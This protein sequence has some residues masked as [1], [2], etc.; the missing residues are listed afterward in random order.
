MAEQWEVILY[1]NGRDIKAKIVRGTKNVVVNARARHI[2]RGL[3]VS[4]IKR[5]K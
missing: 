3:S 2:E 4:G 1:G 5:I